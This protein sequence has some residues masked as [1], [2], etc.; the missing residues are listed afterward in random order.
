MEKHNH[1]KNG[2]N[3]PVKAFLPSLPSELIAEI[4]K[5]CF[6]DALDHYERLFFISLRSVCRTWRS[7]AFST[8]DLWAGLTITLNSELRRLWQE[9]AADRRI[10]RWL[11]RAGDRPLTFKVIR[12]SDPDYLTPIFRRREPLNV[13][14]VVLMSEICASILSS[15]RNWYRIHLPSV[16]EDHVSSAF[17]ER[18]NVDRGHPLLPQDPAGAQL[19]CSMQYPW[20]TLKHLQVSLL[21][22]WPDFRRSEKQWP[23]PSHGLGAQVPS[24]T[25][26]EVVFVNSAHPSIFLPPRLGLKFSHNT[27]RKLVLSFSLDQEAAFSVGIIQN[28]PLLEDL[29][30]AL[31]PTTISWRQTPITHTNVESLTL[32]CYGNQFLDAFTLPNL[33]YLS[34]RHLIPK[35]YDVKLLVSFFSCSECQQL[36]TLSIHLNVPQF[37]PKS[38]RTLW[39]PAYEMMGLKEQSIR[40]ARGA[41][42]EGVWTA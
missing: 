9:A 23:L 30:V 13:M 34:L 20:K 16:E 42:Q 11:D 28:L 26:L 37:K 19:N 15:G 12:E 10:L 5:A 38:W 40:E 2:S 29:T 4:M 8:P 27:L 17:L 32:I 33:S 7:T 14:E 18:F 35:H 41:I 24:L 25:S 39:A 21:I 3:T 22:N 1:Q 36:K 31:A 6:S